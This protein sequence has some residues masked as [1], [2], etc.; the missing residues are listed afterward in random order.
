MFHALIVLLLAA[1]TLVAVSLQKTYSHI[2]SK[3]LKRRTKKGDK[4]AGLLYR[5]VAHGTSLS[6][7]LWIFIGLGAGG[8]FI[9]LARWFPGLVA[10]GVALLFLWIGFAW[11]PKTRV[12]W[13]G[14][15]IA[16][17]FT[18]PIAWLLNNFSPGLNKL[19]YF[20]QK[21]LHTTVHTGLYEKEDIITLIKQQKQQADN[22]ISDEELTIAANALQFGE[23]LV[24][25]SMV[26]RR[27]V[28]MVAAGDTIGPILMDELHASGR[29]RF[30]VYQDKEDN[31]VGTLY[32]RD[33]VSVK[34]GGQVNKIMKKDVRYVHEELPLNHV[35]EAFLKTKHHL[36]M[37]VNNFEEVVGIITIEDLLEQILGQPI[38]DEFDEYQDLRAVAALKA[39]AEHKNHTEVVK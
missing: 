10:L 6:T 30:P 29:S 3:E 33:L 4:L 12:S 37:V 31:I 9:V 24:G 17:L 21:H 38:M 28:K 15:M 2:P 1:V 22:R 20:L 14:L 16:R 39:E 19:A 8:F 18:P 11:L 27:M 26:P 34:T 13:L 23:R 35:L 25:S 32:I 5:A 36:F 7:L